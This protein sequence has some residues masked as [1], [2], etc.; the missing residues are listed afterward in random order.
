MGLGFHLYRSNELRVSLPTLEDGTRGRELSMPVPL[1]K[2][3]FYSGA[4]HTPCCKYT[5]GDQEA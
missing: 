1:L 4:L 5:E 3:D 2:G